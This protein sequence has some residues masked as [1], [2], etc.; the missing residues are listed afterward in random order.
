MERRERKTEE[1]DER[2]REERGERGERGERTPNEASLRRK[3][4]N[5]LPSSLSYLNT[6]ERRD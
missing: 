4:E 3:I 5:R 1:R 2:K 6:C